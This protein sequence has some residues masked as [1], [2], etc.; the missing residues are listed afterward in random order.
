MNRFSLLTATLLACGCYTP[1]LGPVGFYCHPEDSPSCPDGYSCKMI[2]S[3]FRCV[4]SASDAGLSSS[5]LIPKTGAPYSGP[6]NDPMLSSLSSCPDYSSDPTA[7]LEPNDDT[8]HAV[9]LAANPPIPDM[10][11]PKLVHLAICPTGPN[12]AT[13]NHDV[14]YYKIDT[15]SFGQPTLSMMAEI[16]YDITYGDIDVGI[17]DSTGRMLA[18][19]GSAV[20]NGCVA[21]SVGSGVYYVVVVGAN[22]MDVNRYDVRI[23]TFTASHQCPVAGM[24]TDGGT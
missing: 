24:T 6:H 19:D 17:F 10:P 14:D 1:N 18:G 16:F 21:A 11:T 8:A 13:G 4:A 23:R 9:D 12:P 5:S 7:S 22:N 15:T 20:T 2:G 3:D